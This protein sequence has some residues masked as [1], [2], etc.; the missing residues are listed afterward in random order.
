MDKIAQ[1]LENVVRCKKIERIQT[2]REK[3]VER[4]NQSVE[5]IVING[6]SS[7]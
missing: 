7:L 1:I 4:G 2:T 3:M 6:Y 5:N